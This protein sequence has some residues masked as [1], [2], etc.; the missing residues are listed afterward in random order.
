MLDAFEV[1]IELVGVPIAAAELAS[2]AGEG[3]L[4]RRLAPAI[5]RQHL[6]VEDRHGGLGLLGDMQEAEGVGALVFTT[7]RR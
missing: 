2:V 1:E 3:R 5:E 7:A 6:T 4:D